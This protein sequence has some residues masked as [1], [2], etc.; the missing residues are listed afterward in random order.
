MKND[1]ACKL[2]LCLLNCCCTMLVWAQGISS[3]TNAIRQ[4]VERADA[5]VGVAVIV[6]GKDT[7]SFNPKIRNYHP[8]HD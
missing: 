6:D 1:I 5:Q 2:G 3:Q 8:I 4:L 7:L